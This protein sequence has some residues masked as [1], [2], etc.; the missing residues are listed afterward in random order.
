MFKNTII[1]AVLVFLS[2]CAFM[3]PEKSLNKTL[4]AVNNSEQNITR[5]LEGLDANLSKQTNY[6][7]GLESKMVQLSRDVAL[8]KKSHVDGASVKT[9]TNM[10][11]NPKASS[12]VVVADLEPQARTGMVTLGSLEKVYID[13]VKS[14]FVARVDTGAT[15]SSINAID[16]QKFER[17]GKKWVKFHVSDEETAPENRKWVEAPIA[18]HV[19]IRQSSADELERRS[20]VELWVKIGRIHE[21][22]QFTLTDRTQMDYPI[23]LGR[24]FIQDVA[25]VDVSRDFIESKAPKKP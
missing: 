15:T 1:I 16:I 18:R 22:A 17:D 14:A 13:V 5:R 9:L 12:N 3:S 24:E 2:G 19:K 21:K 11:P 8:L 4:E 25:L 6:I 7:D 23:L 10:K 20:V